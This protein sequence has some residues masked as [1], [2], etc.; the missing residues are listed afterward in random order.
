MYAGVLGLMADDSYS[1]ILQVIHSF[2]LSTVE[3]SCCEYLGS[4]VVETDN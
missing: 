4:T 1:A 3:V 2:R